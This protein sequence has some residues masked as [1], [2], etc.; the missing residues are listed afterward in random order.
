MA[1]AQPAPQLWTKPAVLA[2]AAIMVRDHTQANQELAGL[3]MA[4]GVTPLD[5]RPGPA[6]SCHDAR[7]ADR[8]I[9]RIAYV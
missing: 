9:I 2:T 8:A 4:R 5:A 3:A 1:A 7:R 6:R